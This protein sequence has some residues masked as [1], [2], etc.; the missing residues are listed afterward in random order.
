MSFWLAFVLGACGW[1]IAGTG[2]V[3]LA[4]YYEDLGFKISNPRY[5]TP[6]PWDLFHTLAAIVFGPLNLFG[7]IVAWRFALDA[8][9]RK[10]G[11]R[12]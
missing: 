3:T 4:K 2:F 5:P 8:L 10:Q 11:P 6:S 9:E 12:E 1:I 7:V